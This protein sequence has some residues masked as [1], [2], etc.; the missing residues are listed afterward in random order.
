[1]KA[2][3]LPEAV[4]SKNHRRLSLLAATIALLLYPLQPWL[5]RVANAVIIVHYG[6]FVWSVFLVS[7]LFP[8]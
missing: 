6:H 3:V 8:S 1:M 7:F 2:V 4:E 5:P